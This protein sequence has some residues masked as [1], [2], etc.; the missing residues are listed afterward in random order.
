[1]LRYAEMSSNENL[2]QGPDS[3]HGTGGYVNQQEMG[4]E[5]NPFDFSGDAKN[6]TDKYKDDK[7]VY[8]AF[9]RASSPMQKLLKKI[10]EYEKHI[11]R[12]NW[13]IY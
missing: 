5:N 3:G 4:P 10:V 7:T 12:P 8:E 13:G 1:M 6:K 11:K 9:A 2:G